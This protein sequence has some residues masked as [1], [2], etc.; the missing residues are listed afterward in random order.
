MITRSIK[1]LTQYLTKIH[2]NF[3]NRQNASNKR[4]KQTIKKFQDICVKHQH[5]FMHL[6]E[7]ILAKWKCCQISYL[8]FNVRTLSMWRDSS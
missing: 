1:G 2:T 5:G 6:N 3:K 4:N 7:P 8:S